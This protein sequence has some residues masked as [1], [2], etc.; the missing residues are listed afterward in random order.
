[1]PPPLLIDLDRVD[2]GRVLL[3]RNEIYE[4]LPHR[5]EFMLLDGVCMLNAGANELVAFA[6]VAREDWWVRGHVPNRP[7]LP[8]VVMLEMAAQ[9]SALA[10]KLFGHSERFIGFGGVEACKFRETVV[11]P[12]RLYLL[13][14]GREYRPRRIVSGT[15]GVMD[16]RLVFEA[17][18]T[19]IVLR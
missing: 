14:V 5:F 10:V 9:T 2:L 17:T 3:T 12:A 11:P 15:Q 19:G 16:G 1:M 8:G 13:C 6:E 4:H 18:I 7:L